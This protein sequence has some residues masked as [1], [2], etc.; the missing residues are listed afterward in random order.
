FDNPVT[1][2]GSVLLVV[3]AIGVGTAAYEAGNILGGAAGLETITGVNSTI[4]GVII[5]IV[6]GLLLYTGKYKLIERVLIGLVAVMAISFIAS[7]VL[8]GP[9]LGALARGFVPKIPDGSVFLITGLIGTTV[10]GY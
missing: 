1:K 3:A 8:I 6:A 7:A 4:W 10:V 5:G 2:W 9:D